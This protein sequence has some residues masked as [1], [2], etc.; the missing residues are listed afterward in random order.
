MQQTDNNS[1]FLR[2]LALVFSAL[3]ILN[4]AASAAP[5]MTDEEGL[6][7]L[8]QGSE[9][10]TETVASFLV[11]N[12]GGLTTVTGIL[13]FLL[14]LAMIVIAYGLFAIKDWAPTAAIYALSTDIG[15]KILWI[16]L[17][18]VADTP[19]TDLL[20]AYGVVLIEGVLIAALRYYDTHHTQQP[21]SAPA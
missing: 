16:L 6:D 18:W 14:T 17:E 19:I 12:L 15:L 13:V 5:I 11:E 21:A 9:P 4:L 8:G 20:L 3:V 7:Q 10:M 1:V 2:L